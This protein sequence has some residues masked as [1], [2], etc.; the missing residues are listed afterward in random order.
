MDNSFTPNRAAFP[1]VM[2]SL[3]FGGRPV[4]RGQLFERIG[5]TLRSRKNHRSAD[6]DRNGFL[7]RFAIK[8]FSRE[9]H[10]IVSGG[11][12]CMSKDWAIGDHSI[13]EFPMLGEG[14]N[15]LFRHYAGALT[16]FRDF[17]LR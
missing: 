1:T 17:R 14:G 10:C 13:A 9:P 8:T 16:L 5:Q 15:S 6:R 7:C 11:S 12:I 2:E 3:L 4:L